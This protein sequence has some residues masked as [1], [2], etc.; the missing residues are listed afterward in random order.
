MIYRLFLFFIVPE[1]A[2]LGDLGSG[3][4]VVENG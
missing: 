1:F 4:K 3:T 2:K